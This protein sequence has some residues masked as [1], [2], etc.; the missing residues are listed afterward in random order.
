MT[1]ARCI[2]LENISTQQ[3]HGLTDMQPTAELKATKFAYFKLLEN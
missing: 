3:V 2:L 1:G